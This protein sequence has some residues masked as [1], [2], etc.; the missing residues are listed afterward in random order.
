MPDRLD[1]G[2][3]FDARGRSRSDVGQQVGE[4]LRV[5]RKTPSAMRV[6]QGRLGRSP[7]PTRQAANFQLRTGPSGRF[8]RTPNRVPRKL[9]RESGL[10]DGTENPCFAC[11]PGVGDQQEKPCVFVGHHT[12]HLPGVRGRACRSV[13]ISS[14]DRGT[15]ARPKPSNR[16]PAAILQTRPSG[17]CR[18]SPAAGGGGC[19]GDRTPWART[20]H[21]SLKIL[22]LS[23][24]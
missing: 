22:H 20:L 4:C 5:S 7:A 1:G 14:L 17:L 10:T 3:A 21:T 24:T 8:Q 16:R 23:R 13:S 11:L 12:K 6:P 9:V 19:R 18:H 15:A 2:A